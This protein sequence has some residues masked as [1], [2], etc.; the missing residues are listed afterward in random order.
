MNQQWNLNRQPQELSLPEEMQL[1]LPGT[2]GRIPYGWMDIGA[3]AMIDLA[4]AG[5]LTSTPAWLGQPSDSRLSLADES[6]TGNAP[7]DFLIAALQEHGRPWRALPC[8]RRLS[9]GISEATSASLAERGFV[10]PHG[11]IAG[12]GAYLEVRDAPARSAAEERMRASPADL[13]GEALMDI[14][15]R[16]GISW[17]PEPGIFGPRISGD[18]PA[19]ARGTI[20]AVL[21][22]LLSVNGSPA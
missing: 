5:R 19:E 11:G 12:K 9:R 10:R 14:W 7:L 3:A 22:A 8:L 2:E 21:D 17:I 18:Y 15:R 6:P 4:I 1:A 20:V 13:R 16:S